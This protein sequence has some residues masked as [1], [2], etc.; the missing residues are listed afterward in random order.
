MPKVL[1]ISLTLISTTV[2]CGID[3]MSDYRPL[4]PWSSTTDCYELIHYSLTDPCTS[5]GISSFCGIT[6]GNLVLQHTENPVAALMPIITFPFAP[7][8]YRWCTN[9]KSAEEQ[10][11]LNSDLEKGLG[12]THQNITI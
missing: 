3:D 8:I 10:P 7:A 6:F 2:F 4:R 1:L 5:C 9:N 11:L 12:T